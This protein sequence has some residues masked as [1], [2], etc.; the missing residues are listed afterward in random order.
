MG[1]G[2]H[3][4]CSF[5]SKHKGISQCPVWVLDSLCPRAQWGTGSQSHSIRVPSPGRACRYVSSC[6][7]AAEGDLLDGEASQ[8]P[9]GSSL[10]GCSRQRQLRVYLRELELES[11]E[12]GDFISGG[13]TGPDSSFQKLSWCPAEG[14]EGVPAP[15]IIN[16]PVGEGDACG[17]N[18]HS[19][20]GLPR[21]QTDKWTFT[22]LARHSRQAGPYRSHSQSSAACGSSQLSAQRSQW[23]CQGQGRHKPLLYRGHGAKCVRQKL[24]WQVTE[25]LLTWDSA[26]RTQDQECVGSSNRL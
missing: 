20:Q 2:T 17:L 16:S 6:D 10:A 4:F 22:T 25:T 23:G 11:I 14:L 5:S 13:V 21:S 24:R 7:W 1:E 15:E 8:Q 12:E 19:S 9:G 3:P 26:G 18:D